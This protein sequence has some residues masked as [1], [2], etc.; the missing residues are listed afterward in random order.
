MG[1]DVEKCR[2]MKYYR[3]FNYI[4]TIHA[5]YRIDRTR[6]DEFFV[7]VSGADLGTR[8]GVYYDITIHISPLF[9]T[10]KFLAQIMVQEECS[11]TPSSGC[12]IQVL[13]ST[14][15]QVFN[16]EDSFYPCPLVGGRELCHS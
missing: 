11:S 14:A 12:P 8:Y 9:S 2:L 13:I 1:S 7:P 10:L 3:K 5:S 16:N 15:F 4:M 6:I